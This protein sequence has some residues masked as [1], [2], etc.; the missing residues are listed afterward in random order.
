[1]VNE[2]NEVGSDNGADDELS[3]DGDDDDDEQEIFVKQVT[4]EKGKAKIQKYIP[5][6]EDVDT[7]DEEV[8]SPF[9]SFWYQRYCD[10]KN[11]FIKSFVKLICVSSGSVFETLYKVL[12][13]KKI[14]IWSLIF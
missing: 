2:T 5:K 4:T 11:K 3:D 9:H 12:V 6:F 10:L 13:T 8:S 1:M 14:I 7:S